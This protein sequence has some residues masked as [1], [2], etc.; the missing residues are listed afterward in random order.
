MTQ[1]VTTMQNDIVRQQPNPQPEA[2]LAVAEQ[3]QAQAPTPSEEV[4]PIPEQA[5][6]AEQISPAVARQSSNKPV[7]VIMLAL[8]ICVLLCAAV[9]YS[10]LQS[11]S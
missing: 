2:P 3:Q 1:E 7:G 8:I 4:S 11:Q 9:I 6:P 5:L 10:T